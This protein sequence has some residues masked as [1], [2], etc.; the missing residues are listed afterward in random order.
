MVELVLLAV[1]LVRS[2]IL[3]VLLHHGGCTGYGKPYPCSPPLY[4]C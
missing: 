4:G 2:K 1:G 3:L